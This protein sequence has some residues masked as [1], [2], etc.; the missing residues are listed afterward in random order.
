ID[1]GRTLANVSGAMTAAL[2]TDKEVGMLDENTY[3]NP[4]AEIRSDED[5]AI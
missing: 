5:L 1:M 4:G 3:N 2:I